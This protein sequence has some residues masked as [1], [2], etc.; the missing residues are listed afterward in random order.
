MSVH[1]IFDASYSID[2]DAIAKIHRH[3]MKCLILSLILS[4]IK[5]YLWLIY[6]YGLDIF[7]LWL[8]LEIE[9]STLYTS[10]CKRKASFV[11][12]VLLSSLKELDANRNYTWKITM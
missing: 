3:K 5:I 4:Q 12:W 6:I 1:K 10:F 9:I 7:K 11:W 8:A 2:C